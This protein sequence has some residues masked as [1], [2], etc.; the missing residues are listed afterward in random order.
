MDIEP[1]TPDIAR[2]LELPRGKGGAIVTNVSRS[3]PAFNAGVQPNDVILEV[4]RTP[5][6]SV[7]QV[8]RELEGA[9][10]GSTVFVVVWRVTQNG[11]QETFLTLRKR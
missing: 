7:A 4:N 2:E 11:G 9:A 3:S 5:V 6:T 8:K 10:P 1:I